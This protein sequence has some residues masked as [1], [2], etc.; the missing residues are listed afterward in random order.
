M[1]YIIGLIGFPRS[2]KDTVAKLLEPYG[3]VRVAFADKLREALYVLNPI[4]ET[5]PEVSRYQDVLIQYGYDKA[6]ALP[7]VRRL[8]QYLGT[9]VGRN[10]I[11][12]N[13]WVDAAL[14]EAEKHERVVI[15]DVRFHNE[16][17]AVRQAGGKIVNV[18]RGEA[19]CDHTHESE[20]LAAQYAKNPDLADF[21]IKNDGPL[22]Q[23]ETWVEL[24]CIL[25]GLEL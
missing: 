18:L 24:I 4:V 7:E 12:K 1:S 22:E 3:F 15:T 20:Q 11:G 8:L 5:Q 13:V 10:I 2:G 19:E 17:H 23:L 6:K 16:V 14:R 9:E 25:L 21:T